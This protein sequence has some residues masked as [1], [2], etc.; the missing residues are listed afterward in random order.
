MSYTARRGLSITGYTCSSG[1]WE[2]YQVHSAQIQTQ[3]L[4]LADT[5]VSSTNATS[6]QSGTAGW[7]SGFETSLPSR[8]GTNDADFTNA[9]RYGWNANQWRILVDQYGKC[10]C[11][12]TN[13]S[14]SAATGVT[15]DYWYGPPSNGP[16][17]SSILYGEQ[18]NINEGAGTLTIS[19]SSLQCCTS[20]EFLSLFS[21]TTTKTSVTY[22]WYRTRTAPPYNVMP[23]F[24]LSSV[25]VRG[26]TLAWLGTG[27]PCTSPS[28]SCIW[29]AG[30]N[31]TYLHGSSFG[32]ASPFDDGSMG[33]TIS[34]TDGSFKIN[35]SSEN[36][37]G[38][39]WNISNVESQLE[40]NMS[41]LVM[42][43]IAAADPYNNPC[44]YDTGMEHLVTT[45]SA[46]NSFISAALTEA[47]KHDLN[48]WHMDFEWG[49]NT[50]NSTYAGD[51][52]SF[53][54]QLSSSLHHNGMDLAVDVYPCMGTLK[55][56]CTGKMDYTTLSQQSGV[57]YI[58]LE[59]YTNNYTLGK[60]NFVQIYQGLTG[61]NVPTSKIMVALGA[62]G[63]GSFLANNPI[64]E[65]CTSYLIQQGVPGMALW[66]EWSYWLPTYNIQ[67]GTNWYSQL[68]IYEQTS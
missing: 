62:Q 18:M 50:W 66:S 16:S 37:F 6:A 32:I 8:S 24:A 49:C 28:S 36:V 34:Q 23:S 52:V 59:D 12:T 54:N 38:H 48:G 40:T 29:Q 26:Y 15:S 22:Q 60:D 45:Q 39:S 68:S 11:R 20:Y 1:T 7:D 58:A 4:M 61:E 57:D 21:K 41:V 14:S 10:V 27:N 53:L 30:L 64:I 51:Y 35:G 43:T 47:D 33:Y 25:T 13:E 31:G 3:S 2:Q 19:G 63:D 9:N 46:K 44:K 42:P 17:N 55:N 65:N 56:F 67:D 5:F